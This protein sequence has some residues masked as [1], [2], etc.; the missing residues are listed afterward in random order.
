MTLYACVCYGNTHKIEEIDSNDMK[1]L[2][3]EH[4]NF[5]DDMF[6]RC[7]NGSFYGNIY[8]GRQL[9]AEKS[10]RTRKMCARID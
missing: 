4:I 1:R 9:Y 8:D 2:G 10:K 6:C 5:N 3:R 7:K